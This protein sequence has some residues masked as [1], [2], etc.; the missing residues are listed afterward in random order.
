MKNLHFC[1]LIY[2]Y[3]IKLRIAFNKELIALERKIV[4]LNANIL[5]QVGTFPPFQKTHT[6]PMLEIAAS[7]Q[8]SH[9]KE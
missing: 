9:L 3:L 4:S 5:P 2:Q 1:T 8:N 6:F 7:A